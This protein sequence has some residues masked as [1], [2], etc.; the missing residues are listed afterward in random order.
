MLPCSRS[1]PPLFLELRDWQARAGLLYATCSIPYN[2]LC[3][4]YDT[5]GVQWSAGV[6][7]DSHVCL[8]ADLPNWDLL[9]YMAHGFTAD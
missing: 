5:V 8:N 2:D 9:A 4:F 7:G 6:K 3:V 1:T